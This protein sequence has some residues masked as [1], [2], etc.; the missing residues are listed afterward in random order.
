MLGPTIWGLHT[1]GCDRHFVDLFA[2]ILLTPWKTTHLLKLQTVF[3]GRKTFLPRMT[4]CEIQ[5]KPVYLKVV[6]GISRSG[7]HDKFTSL[8]GQPSLLN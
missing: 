5:L 3:R 6:T 8:C 4:H 1:F 7:K 2:A